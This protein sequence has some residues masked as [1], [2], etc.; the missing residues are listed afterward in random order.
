MEV[1]ILRL[2]AGGLCIAPSITQLTQSLGDHC[3]TLVNFGFFIDRWVS[4]TRIPVVLTCS[5]KGIFDLTLI[6]PLGLLHTLLTAPF[7][8][9]L[10]P[11]QPETRIHRQLP[12]TLGQSCPQGPQSMFGSKW[13]KYYT[14]RGWLL[15]NTAYHKIVTRN[16]YATSTKTVWKFGLGVV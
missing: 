10:V 3:L 6:V 5:E 16:I 4:W 15:G 14:L 7:A 2:D 12:A 13:Q 1:I 9:L 8:M 11:P